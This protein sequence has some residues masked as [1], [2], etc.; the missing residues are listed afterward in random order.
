MRE[1]FPPLLM[2][3]AIRKPESDKRLVRKLR[4]SSVNPQDSTSRN[5][6]GKV[7]VSLEMAMND[8][9]NVTSKETGMRP[10]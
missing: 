5:H 2:K 8:T 10:E 6:V 7:E 1:A 4:N 3:W 9:T